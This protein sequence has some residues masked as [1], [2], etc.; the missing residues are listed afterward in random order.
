MPRLGFRD[1]VPTILN[2]MPVAG[3]IDGFKIW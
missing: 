2:L 3:L 1:G